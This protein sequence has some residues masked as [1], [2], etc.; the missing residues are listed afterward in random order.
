MFTDLG[1]EVTLKSGE[2]NGAKVSAA[3]PADGD[4]LGGDFLVADD[5][6]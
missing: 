3:A 2:R 1:E 6:E 5:E 4:G